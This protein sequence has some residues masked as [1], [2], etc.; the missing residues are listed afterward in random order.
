M[1]KKLLV[2]VFDTIENTMDRSVHT[3]IMLK[4]RKYTMPADIERSKSEELSDALKRL[5]NLRTNYDPDGKAF[6]SSF[7][8]RIRDGESIRVAPEDDDALS[9]PTVSCVSFSDDDFSLGS[10]EDL[11]AKA[12]LRLP[13][14]KFSAEECE[15][16]SMS[17]INTNAL[18]RIEDLK[19]KLEIQENTK[20]ELLNQ[21]MRLETELEKVDSNFA[22]ARILKVE[23][24]GL[25]EQSAQMEKDLLNEIT[26][27]MKQVVEK[28]EEYKTNLM[29]RDKRIEKLEEDIALLQITKNVDPP[30]VITIPIIN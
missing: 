15:D 27:L 18:K 4:N 3:E 2:L 22:R 7:F 11:L 9:S 16:L 28:E 13:M 29:E 23:N 19:T 10:A 24:A 8:D 30:S 5:S 1:T 17:S 20:L 25:R 26:S 12:K 6:Q 14:E 21:C